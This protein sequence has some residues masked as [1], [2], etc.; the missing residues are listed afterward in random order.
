MHANKVQ[1]C[2]NITVFD[3]IVRGPVSSF[4]LYNDETAKLRVY[5]LFYQHYKLSRCAAFF[6][7]CVSSLLLLILESE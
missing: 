4:P 7:S 3:G 2:H 6:G 1:R 5:G